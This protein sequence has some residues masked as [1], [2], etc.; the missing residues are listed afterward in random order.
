MSL[1]HLLQ[2]WE[3]GEGASSGD[4]IANSHPP[5]A[6]CRHQK[7]QPLRERDNGGQIYSCPELM[8]GDANWREIK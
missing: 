3:R 5:A 6:S 4:F 2:E 7:S 1:C 8:D